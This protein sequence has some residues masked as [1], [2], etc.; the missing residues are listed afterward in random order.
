MVTLKCVRCQ[1]MVE[2]CNECLCRLSPCHCDGPQDTNHC[3]VIEI[4]HS[5]SLHTKCQCGCEE[6]VMMKCAGCNQPAKGCPRCFNRLSPCGCDGD[7]KSSMEMT[8]CRC[9]SENIGR[10]ECAVC[11]EPAAGCLQCFAR[12]GACGCDETASAISLMV[13]MPRNGQQCPYGN[14][15]MVLMK[16]AD[17]LQSAIGCSVCY[18][19]H[20]PCICDAAARASEA[21][22]MC[23]PLEHLETARVIKENESA[24]LGIQ[25]ESLKW[26]GDK[27]VEDTNGAQSIDQQPCQSEEQGNIQCDDGLA[28]YIQALEDRLMATDAHNAELKCQVKQ[29]VEK[30][31][32]KC[33]PQCE[34]I[35]PSPPCQPAAN[36]KA[37][38]S[39][40]SRSANVEGTQDPHYEDLIRQQRELGIPTPVVPCAY[41]SEVHDK[42]DKAAVP[43]QDPCVTVEPPPMKKY[44]VADGNYV[45][46]GP[47]PDDETGCK[48]DEVQFVQNL[49]RLLK[50]SML[51]N[52]ELMMNLRAFKA[53]EDAIKGMV[54][55]PSCVAMREVSCSDIQSEDCYWKDRFQQYSGH[56]KRLK[57]V[58]EICSDRGGSDECP[59]RIRNC[60]YDLERAKK[61]FFHAKALRLREESQHERQCPRYKGTD[62][63]STIDSTVWS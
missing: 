19:R 33:V 17:C 52:T 39:T 26:Y 36:K 7:S 57:M 40:K 3:E 54:R 31:K 22:S 14:E 9:G 41:S 25:C 20:S 23:L 38:K 18:R 55:G 63:H 47:N 34:P 30:E 44:D 6:I 51:Q 43:M 56:K 11:H 42:T 13:V 16:C 61:K 53:K 49:Q 62:D 45:C 5:I 59:R 10:M 28:Q 12:I 60:D 46:E 37:T 4:D 15:K 29:H 24:S 2:G 58:E 50:I 48:Q 8:Q 1:S 35:E 27:A 21:Q 32:P